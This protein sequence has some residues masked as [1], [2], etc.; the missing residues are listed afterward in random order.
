MSNRTIR[1]VLVEDEPIIA[2]DLSQQ[3]RKSGI[4]VMD[5][6]EDGA[7]ALSYLEDEQPDVIILDIQLYGDLDG[8]DVANQ[9]NQRHQIPIIF[10]TSNTESRTFNRAKLTYPHAFLSKPF[11]IRDVLHA[12]ELAMEQNEDSSTATTDDL[13]NDAIFIRNKDSLEKVL[14]SDI[15]FMKADGAYT[16]IKT[17]DKE[18]VFS[19]NMKK[20]EEKI[21]YK[22]LRRVH[23]SYIVNISKVDRLSHGYLY[24]GNDK[25][26]ISRSYREELLQLFKTL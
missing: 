20:V 1:A 10:L 8:V 5:I 17:A 19:Q 25:V 13:V 14:F 23:R 16:Q 9:V 12:I 24:I 3:L 15:L 7:S 21:N 6:F 26:P 4:E 2:A 11:R 22:N 18:F